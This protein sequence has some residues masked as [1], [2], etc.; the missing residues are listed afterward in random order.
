MINVIIHTNQAP[1]VII[2]HSELY[3]YVDEVDNIGQSVKQN[4]EKTPL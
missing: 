1:I 3:K 2:G 4:E